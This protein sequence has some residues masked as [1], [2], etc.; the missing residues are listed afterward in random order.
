V[1]SDY[2]KGGDNDNSQGKVSGRV[3]WDARIDWRP[4]NG[5]T[6]YAKALNLLD[7]RTPTVVYWSGF[8]E[9]WYP[10]AGREFDFGAI[11][12]Y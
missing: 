6:L 3:G 1:S 7:S 12:H 2:F 9:S 5:L 4:L 11:W 10:T 8:G